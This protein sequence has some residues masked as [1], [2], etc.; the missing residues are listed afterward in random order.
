MLP[1]EEID[2]AGCERCKVVVV[3][4]SGVGKSSLLMRF[5]ANSF[6][7]FSLSLSFSFVLFFLKK[8]QYILCA[9]TWF[10]LSCHIKII[11]YKDISP[12]LPL[13]GTD[14]FF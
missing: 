6:S 8:F 9:Y 10:V 11:Q 13:T 1:D 2:L 4:N 3:G 14:K 12:Y 5:A 7:G